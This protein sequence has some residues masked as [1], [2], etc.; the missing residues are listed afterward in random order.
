MTLECSNQ[1][2]LGDEF[3]S[4]LRRAS[5]AGSLVSCTARKQAF[6]QM[7]MHGYLDFPRA[8]WELL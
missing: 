6:V 4:P 2:K 1:G 8:S 3:P 7:T 5:M